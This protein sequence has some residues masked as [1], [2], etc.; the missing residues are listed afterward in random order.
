MTLSF[1]IPKPQ[2]AQSRRARTQT[3]VCVG[4][5]LLAHQLILQ[6]TPQIRGK[7]VLSTQIKLAMNIQYV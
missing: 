7:S 5:E 1:K 3:Q 4:L 6:M 2:I